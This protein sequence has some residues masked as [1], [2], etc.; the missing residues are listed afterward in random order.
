MGELEKRIYEHALEVMPSA[1]KIISELK[2]DARYVY[3]PFFCD[4]CL[5]KLVYDFNANR[6]TKIIYSKGVGDGVMVEGM[7]YIG[8]FDDVEFCEIEL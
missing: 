5:D 3:V 6:F 1:I 2:T 8:W 4:G 7:E